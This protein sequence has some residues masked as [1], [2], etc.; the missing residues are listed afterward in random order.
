MVRYAVLV[1]VCSRVMLVVFCSEASV[2]VVS[3]FAVFDLNLLYD[4]ELLWL[5]MLDLRWW[6]LIKLLGLIDVM[7][8]VRVSW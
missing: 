1:V 2:E 5:L 4:L 7:L 3:V 6:L 8:V